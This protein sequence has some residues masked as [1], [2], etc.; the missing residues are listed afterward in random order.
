M[1][2]AVVTTAPKQVLAPNSRRTKWVIEFLPTSVV[3][4]NA[5]NVFLAFGNPPGNS[6]TGGA[7]DAVLIPG[8]SYVRNLADGHSKV[9]VQGAIWLH[10]ENADQV[11]LIREDLSEEI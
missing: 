7:Y 8:A 10:A 2:R 5:G 4:G 11:L 9:E 1:A 6:L 3:G